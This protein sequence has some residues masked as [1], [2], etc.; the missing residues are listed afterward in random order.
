MFLLSYS[1]RTST[2]YRAVEAYSYL[3]PLFTQLPLLKEEMVVLSRISGF[4]MD[5][6]SPWARVTRYRSSS[7]TSVMR[8][9]SS[10]DT[11]AEPSLEP[12]FT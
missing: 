8:A 10:S 11:R 12:S 1:S 5:W 4:T 2:S 9:K 7:F 6:T 3:L